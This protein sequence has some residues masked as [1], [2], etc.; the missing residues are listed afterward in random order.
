MQTCDPALVEG[1][2]GE[3]TSV[4]V[5]SDGTIWVAGYNDSDGDKTLYGDL[6]AGKWDPAKMAVQWADVDGVPTL[7]MGQCSE[8]DPT[9]WRGGIEDPGPDVG[10][11]TSMVLDPSSQN[12]MIAY[13]DA[14]NAQAKFATYNG[15]TWNVYVLSQGAMGTD[16][17]RYAKMIL[18]NGTPVVAY[19]GMEAGM[20]GY[21][22]SRV[23][24]ATANKSPPGATDWTY[25]DAAVNEQNPCQPQ[26]CTASQA[27]LTTTGGVTG[28]CTTTVN[29]CN[30]ACSSSQACVTVKS[31]ATCVSA[32]T[33]SDWYPSYQ[34]VW[35]DYISLQNGP[36]GLGLAVYDRFHGNLWAI[37]KSGGMWNQTL[38][39]G[40]TGTGSMTVDTGDDGIAAN[41]VIAPNG[42]WNVAYVDG[43][44]EALKFIV[45]PGGQGM[46]LN[47]EVIDD[48]YNNGMPYPDGQ[49]IVGDDVNISIDG[50]GN[51]TA[52]YQDSTAGIL[53][54]ATGVP[55]TGGVHKWVAQDVMPAAGE[56]AGF[57]PRFVGTTP[58]IANW[59][60]LADTTDQ[61][62]SGDVSLVMM[63]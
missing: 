5:A 31:A 2:I 40:Q 27:C 61:T 58:Q 4:A 43:T 9:G 53:R 46:P 24:V 38:L 62:E 20:N 25:E 41:L 8:A 57:F 48:G 1:L 22:R 14:T 29:G 34:P 17:G 55:S 44:T 59:W 47:P 32:Y 35:G 36:N 26:F 15:T 16:Q 39:D 45:W 60:R 7:P 50:S 49:H 30:P 37:N 18:V 11:W 51:V 19:L 42:D 21:T 52:I 23:I 13:Y 56:F 10:L 54:V 28:V 6:V 63:P 33:T 12:P 3:Y